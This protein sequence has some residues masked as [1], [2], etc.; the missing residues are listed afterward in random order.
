MTLLLATTFAL[1]GAVIGA[2]LSVCVALLAAALIVLSLVSVA[3]QGRS[4][5]LT[6]DAERKRAMVAVRLMETTI[7]A[8]GVGAVASILALAWPVLLMRVCAF[9]LATAAVLAFL[10]MAARTVGASMSTG[11]GS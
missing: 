10:G 4:F 6:A 1:D 3:Q 8:S 5:S 11:R 9:V 2:C 7:W